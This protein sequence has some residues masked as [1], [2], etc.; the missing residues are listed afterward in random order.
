[1]ENLLK[2]HGRKYTALIKGK[3]VEG[4][5]IVS[6]DVAYL[7]QNEWDGGSPSTG[8]PFKEY[9]YTW[10]V[11]DGTADALEIEDVE[12]F[13]LIEEAPLELRQEVTKPQFGK[14]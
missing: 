5:V 12:N 13:K 6:N 4:K 10:Y 3:S 2:A 8:N 11:A 1:M 14:Y 9:Q 7:A